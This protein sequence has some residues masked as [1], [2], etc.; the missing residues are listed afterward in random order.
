M[1]RDI[2]DHTH[3]MPLLKVYHWYVQ[4]LFKYGMYVSG[5]REFVLDAITQLFVHVRSQGEP[6]VNRATLR[7]CL[8]KRFR[9]LISTH[10]VGEKSPSISAPFTNGPDTA[11]LDMPGL[12]LSRHQREAAF[13]KLYC[14]FSYEQVAAIMHLDVEMT[15]GL[16]TQSFEILRRQ[17]KKETVYRRRI[18]DPI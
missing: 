9:D 12:D 15:Y 6:L 1:S 2:F 16:L 11:S 4:R 3:E 14:E 10:A 7:F 8:F 18:A 17:Y 13:L 5:D